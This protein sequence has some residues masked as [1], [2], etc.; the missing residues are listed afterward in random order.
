M[1][2]T[3][4]LVWG[5]L[6]TGTI[7][8]TFAC[9]IA[10]SSTANIHGMPRPVSRLIMG[11][12]TLHARDL[13]LTCTLLDAFVARGG[14]TLDTAHVYGGGESER[15]V[16][17]WMRLR[18]NRADMILVGKGAAPGAFTGRYSPDDRSNGDMARVWYNDGSFA[19]LRRVEE[20]SRERGV[21]TAVVALAFVLG[22]PFP[23]FAIIGPRTLE[24]LDASTAALSVRLT[25]EELAWL[26]L[27][28]PT[29]GRDIA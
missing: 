7:A 11:T 14:N 21:S 16:G 18:G 10:A 6:G 15:A 27:E 26:N 28:Q 22:Q 13:P 23:I 20:L 24:E 9:G 19:R 3:G 5:I 25:A 8:K 29:R 1:K 12:M 17:E 4:E 2:Q